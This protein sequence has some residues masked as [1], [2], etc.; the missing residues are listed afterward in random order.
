MGKALENRSIVVGGYG[1]DGD[2]LLLL[3]NLILNL[4]VLTAVGTSVVGAQ[5][6]VLGTTKLEDFSQGLCNLRDWSG[7][8]GG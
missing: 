1:Q 4:T 5:A 2:L 8:A 7:G 6:S 3:L